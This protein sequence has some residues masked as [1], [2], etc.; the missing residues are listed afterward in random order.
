MDIPEFRGTIKKYRDI[1]GIRT[2]E[3]LRSHTDV[4]SN[5]T[6]SKYMR[7]PDLMPVRVMEQIFKA[8]NVPYE[9]RRKCLGI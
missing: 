5:T 1:R 3:Q 9:D 4:G 2:Q 6:F 8:L 7:E